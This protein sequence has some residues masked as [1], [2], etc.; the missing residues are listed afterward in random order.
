MGVLSLLLGITNVHHPDANIAAE[1]K[2]C[3]RIGQGFDAFKYP[4][5][6]SACVRGPTRPVWQ[7]NQ[8]SVLQ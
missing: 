4:L 8:G 7:C 1:I 2:I 3:Q 6:D 5:R